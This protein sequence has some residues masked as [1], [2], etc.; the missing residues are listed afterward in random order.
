M[1]RRYVDHLIAHLLSC[2]GMVHVPLLC[3]NNDQTIVWWFIWDQ[4]WIIIAELQCTNPSESRGENIH[5][6]VFML[7]DTLMCGCIKLWLN[8]VH[9]KLHYILGIYMSLAVAKNGSSLQEKKIV[10]RFRLSKLFGKM[11]YHQNLQVRFYSMWD[12]NVVHLFLECWAKS[13]FSCI[14]LS[15]MCLT[16]KFRKRYVGLWGSI[17]CKQWRTW[18][19]IS[20][21]ESPFYLG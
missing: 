14:S 17:P 10:N 2:T 15:G 4:N 9:A 16:R 12:G 3:C 5:N 11:T 1:W 18:I 13:A 21:I 7:T 20:S 19:I 6:V 8:V